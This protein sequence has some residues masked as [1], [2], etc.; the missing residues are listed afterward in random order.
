MARSRNRCYNANTTVRSLCMVVDLHIAVN[1]I[2][3]LSAAM[4]TQQW[5]PLPLLSRHKTLR[6][7]VNNINVLGS[8][9]KVPDVVARF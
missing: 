6:T 7:A 8:S 2:K 1:N 9:C 3:T 5:V 4:E